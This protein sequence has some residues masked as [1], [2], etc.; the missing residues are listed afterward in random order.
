ML[1]VDDIFEGTYKAGNYSLLFLKHFAM[2]IVGYKLRA[3]KGKSI[4][5]APE[6]INPYLNW[7]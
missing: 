1:K 7:L 3:Q 5:N 4:L 2:R 6:S